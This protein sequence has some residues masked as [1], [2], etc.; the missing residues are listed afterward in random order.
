MMVR[1]EKGTGDD[2]YFEGGGGALSG[3]A[4]GKV[5]RKESE[6]KGTRQ[7]CCVLSLQR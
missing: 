1:Q 3:A 4:E 5:V 6:R 2:E 7:L